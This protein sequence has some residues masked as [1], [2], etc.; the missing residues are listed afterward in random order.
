MSAVPTAHGT[1][2][3]I[4]MTS[5]GCFNGSTIWSLHLRGGHADQIVHYSYGL[6]EVWFGFGLLL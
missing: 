1:I 5:G 3:V 4:P 6:G 2:V